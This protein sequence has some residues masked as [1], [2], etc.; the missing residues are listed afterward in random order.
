MK[1]S[2]SPAAKGGRRHT[3]ECVVQGIYQWLLSAESPDRIIAHLRDDEDFASADADH[4]SALLHGV[5]GDAEALRNALSRYLDRPIPELSPVEHAILL[6]GAHELLHRP[7]VPYRVVINEAIEIAKRFGGTDG[8]KY[9][10][11]V[12]DKFAQAELVR[13]GSIRRGEARR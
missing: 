7:E 11:G 2:H 3:R 4:C 5:I 13:E 12:L 10:N 1:D 6:L 9:V 8:H